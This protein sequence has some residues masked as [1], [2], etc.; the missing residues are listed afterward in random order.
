MAVSLGAFFFYAVYKVYRA[1]QARPTTGREGLVGDL[2][3]T[4]TDLAPTGMVFIEGELWHATSLDGSI[5]S[6][7]KVRVVAADGLQLKVK[8]EPNG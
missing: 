4:R 6:G 5:P 2:A 1:R 8:R 3:E 7:E